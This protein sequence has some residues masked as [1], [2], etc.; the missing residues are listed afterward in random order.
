MHQYSV[1]AILNTNFIIL[2]SI[3]FVHCKKHKT[4]KQ[5]CLFRTCLRETKDPLQLL[6]SRQRVNY[7]FFLHSNRKK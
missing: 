3:I 1:A 4:I 2:I 6:V 7:L 5:T